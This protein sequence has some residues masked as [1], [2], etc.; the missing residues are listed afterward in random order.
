[1]GMYVDGSIQSPQIRFERFPLFCTSCFD[2][3][4]NAVT[5]V[6]QHLYIR[7]KVRFRRCINARFHHLM[8]RNDP[9]LFIDPSRLMNFRFGVCVF[10]PQSPSCPQVYCMDFT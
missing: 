6:Y 3:L 9:V 1:M 8:E 7:P 4:L 5:D 10:H 2:G